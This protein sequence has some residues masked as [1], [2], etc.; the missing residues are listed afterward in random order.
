MAGKIQSVLYNVDQTDDTNAEE[1][2][3]AQR[4]ILGELSSYAGMYLKVNKDGDGLDFGEGGSGA[5]ARIIALGN[6]GTPE[7]YNLIKGYIDNGE[8]VILFSTTG[9]NHV[10][11]TYSGNIGGSLLF[12]SYQGTKLGRLSYYTRN[13]ASSGSYGVYEITYENVVK[14]YNSTSTSGTEILEAYADGQGRIPVVYENTYGTGRMVYTFSGITGNTEPI[15]SRVDETNK[16]LVI[17]TYKTTGL[18][19]TTIPLS[20]EAII[21]IN[22]SSLDTEKTSYSTI[23]GIIDAG[24][25]PVVE[26]GGGYSGNS[27]AIFYHLHNRSFTN[28]VTPPSFS[29]T[30]TATELID[31]YAGDYGGYAEKSLV[32]TNLDCNGNVR[33]DGN[34]TKNEH[35]VIMVLNGSKTGVTGKLPNYTEMKALITAGTEVIIKK[36]FNNTRYMF[37]VCSDSPYGVI[38][39]AATTQPS[40]DTPSL[41]RIKLGS[42]NVWTDLPAIDLGGGSGGSVNPA[43]STQIPVFVDSTGTVQQCGFGVSTEVTGN[44]AGII[45]FR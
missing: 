8:N 26:V 29:F 30:F 42:D 17:M 36:T 4:N 18:V 19:K 6:G 38:F 22:A 15:F 16:Q 3:Q 10:Y 33:D 14:A 2:Q 32:I 24:L 35:R 12:Y 45:Y 25:S 21:T 7:Q 27:G 1:R 43:G 37:R 5:G 11:W 28:S 9:D 44:T 34:W 13:T 23:Q 20:N 31:N 41:Y 39:A 40:N